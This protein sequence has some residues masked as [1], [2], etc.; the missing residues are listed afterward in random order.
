MR[1]PALTLPP[2]LLAL[3]PPAV[4]AAASTEHERGEQAERD[5]DRERHQSPRSV[6][7]VSG[8]SNG[9]LDG[10]CGWPP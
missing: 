9:L 7:R 3:Q 4:R 8:T 10:I 2:A 1:R 5:Q 6:R